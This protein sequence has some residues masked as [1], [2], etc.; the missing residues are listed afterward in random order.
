MRPAWAVENMFCHLLAD[1]LIEQGLPVEELGFGS[2]SIPL[3]AGIAFFHWPSEVFYVRRLRSVQTVVMLLA[4]MAYAKRVH[5]MKIVWLA[6]NVVPHDRTGWRFLPARETFLRLLDGV[7]YLSETSRAAVLAAY[8]KLNSLPHLIVPHGVYLDQVRPAAPPAFTTERPVRIAYAGRVKS[9][10]APD[11]LARSTAVLPADTV[12]LVVAGA[13][14]EP[15]LARDLTAIAARHP[16]ITTHLAF[17]EHDE[18][19]GILDNADAIVMPYRDILN[20]GSAI[21]ALSR[22]RPF[23]APRLGS[24]VELQQ[25]V[26]IEWVWLYDGDLTPETLAAALRWVRDTPR[27]TGPD[28]SYFQWPSIGARLG[29]FLRAIA[30]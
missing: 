25:Q 30:R 14:S 2:R 10:K 28:L 22:F 18:L 1:A 27:P 3:R 21:H 5:G 20:S 6:H 16:N 9:Y 23:I 7:V 13:C 19:E 26:G 29:N 17:L 12:E 4:K 15:E 24:L 11:V 8:P